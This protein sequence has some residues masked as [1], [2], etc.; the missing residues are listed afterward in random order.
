MS[1][2]KAASVLQSRLLDDKN[3]WT[4]AVMTWS[5]LQGELADSKTTVKAS[6][7]ALGVSEREAE[8]GGSE[9]QR[10]ERKT[11]LVESRTST[12]GERK[13]NI[14]R[15]RTGEQN[16]VYSM[17]QKRK[18]D[19]EED[20]ERKVTAWD[21]SIEKVVEERMREDEEA[22]A[23]MI[24]CRKNVRHGTDFSDRRSFCDH[25]T[26]SHQGE[27]SSRRMDGIAKE[28]SGESEEKGNAIKY[29]SIPLFI[30]A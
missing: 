11:S 18:R 20:R 26:S 9:E 16:G 10:E 22:E 17:A 28:F 7:S 3:Q 27:N 14:G 15:Q 8:V 25:T 1:I 2:A 4:S 23:G 12:H 29:I 30:S 21:T 13:E 6:S 24:N 5:R 19:D